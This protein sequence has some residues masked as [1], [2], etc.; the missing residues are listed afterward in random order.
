MQLNSFNIF[1]ITGGIGYSFFN[2]IKDKGLKICGFY[3]SNDKM[4]SQIKLSDNIS[5]RRI[6]MGIPSGIK[7]IDIPNYEGLLYAVGKPHFGK[8]IFDFQESE[9]QAQMNMSINSL[10]VI[11]QKLCSR[12]NVSLKRVV[13]ISSICPEVIDSLYH[14]VKQMQSEF[15][16][17]LRQVLNNRNIGLSIIKAGWV[18]TKMFDEYIR[19]TGKKPRSAIEPIIIAKHCIE[20]FEREGLFNEAILV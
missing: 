16:R 5:L 20:E 12:D 9:L 7:E 4:I 8:N 13:V 6:D 2:E 11:L 18:K 10:F 14:I 15:L 3:H 1:G 17:V 19:I